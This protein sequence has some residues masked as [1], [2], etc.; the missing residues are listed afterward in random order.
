[1]DTS[2]IPGP[3]TALKVLAG[4]MAYMLPPVPPAAVHP[5]LQGQSRVY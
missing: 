4:H 5:L 2:D 1:M 3:R